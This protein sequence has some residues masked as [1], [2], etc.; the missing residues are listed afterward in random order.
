MARDYDAQVA[1]IHARADQLKG[2]QPRLVLLG[3]SSF[4]FWPATDTV[5]SHFEVVNA[6]FGGSCFQDAWRLRDTLIYALNPDVLMIYEGDNDLHD[7]VPIDD[8]VATASLLLEDVSMR[9]PNLDVV[10]VAPKAS[11]ARHHLKAE[12]LELNA[13]LRLLA[14]E[15]RRPLVGFLG[16]STPRGRHVEGRFVHRRPPP[17]QRRRV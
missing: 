11:P 12:Y 9:M 13:S 16:R 6:G 5:F 7:R 8:I 3:S 4:R 14:M 17:P 2:E 15:S 1:A 10:V